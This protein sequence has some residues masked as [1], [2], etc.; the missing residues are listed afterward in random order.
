M[1]HTI[2]I[3][4]QHVLAN[5]LD[6][7]EV[8]RREAQSI[9]DW[10][11]MKRE[12]IQAMWTQRSI[13]SRWIALRNASTA[14]NQLD[15]MREATRVLGRTVPRANMSVMHVGRQYLRRTQMNNTMV[16]KMFEARLALVRSNDF[17]LIYH[18]TACVNA[19]RYDPS[20]APVAFL[21]WCGPSA[22]SEILAWKLMHM[23]DQS[24]V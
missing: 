16:F 6:Y 22:I 20:L 23:V 24:V 14:N 18:Y 3:K 8:V 9:V 19:Q 12:A 1:P 4:A 7:P 11:R 2:V 21:R 5:E 10:N 17:A 13:H 15:R